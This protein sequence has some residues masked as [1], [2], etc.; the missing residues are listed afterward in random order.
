M[1]FLLDTFFGH[2]VNNLFLVPPSVSLNPEVTAW[3]VRVAAAGGTVS[4]STIAAVDAFVSAAKAGG[5][6]ALFRR[7]NL[8]CGD[9]AAS[10]VPLVNTSGGTTDTNVNLVSGDYSESLGWQTDG[11]T[12][13]VNTGYTPSEAT[14]G[15]SVY[16]RTSVNGT[17]CAIGCRDAGSQIFRLIGLGTPWAA[18][19]GIGLAT[20]DDGATNNGLIQSSRESVG[21]G[22]KIFRNGALKATDPTSATPASAGVSLL[23]MCQSSNGTPAAF[24][25]AASRLSAYGVDAGMST[26]QASAYYT[27]MQAFQTALGRQV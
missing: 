5:F 15:L 12:K 13:Y 7:L 1:S 27:A 8:C 4:A 18:F 26:V 17:Q 20:F 9:F 19:W 10:F 11:S 23:V 14:G 2:R 22:L 3:L 25:P 6:W 16:M 21:A 24:L